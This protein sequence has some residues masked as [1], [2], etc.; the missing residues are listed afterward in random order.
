M[1]PPKGAPKTP[2]KPPPKLTAAKTGKPFV[3]PAYAYVTK[4]GGEKAAPSKALTGMVSATFAPRKCHA[5]ARV[6][7]ALT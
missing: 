5:S 7:R 6:A 3:A 4:Y 1:P 2:L